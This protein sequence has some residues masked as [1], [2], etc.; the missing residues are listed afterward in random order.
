MKAWRQASIATEKRMEQA[1]A[2]KEKGDRASIIRTVRLIRR[3]AISRAGKP[4]ESKGLGD[5]AYGIIWE[6]I[7]TK[8][9]QRK[10][11]IQKAAWAFVPE[12]E[13]RV[14]VDKILP[15]LGVYAAPR[16]G[17]LRNAHL[18]MWTEVYAPETAD[19]AADHLELLLSDMADDKMPTW[20]MHATQMRQMS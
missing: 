6:Q 5:L 17:G 11:R 12:E 2:R 19:E 7:A 14:K 1:K 18:R 16:P 15:K 20:F 13:L 9:P 3:G 10:Q 4:M 8:H